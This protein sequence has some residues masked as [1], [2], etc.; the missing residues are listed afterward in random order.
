MILVVG[1]A[2][3]SCVAASA[4]QV[5]FV[6]A[7]R[8]TNRIVNGEAASV[9]QFPWQVSMKQNGYHFCGGSIVGTKYIVSAAHC[10][11]TNTVFVSM[12][13]VDLSDDGAYKREI[14]SFVKHPDYNSNTLDYDYSV[15]TMKSAIPNNVDSV[16]VIEMAAAQ[17][18]KQYSG[19]ATTSGWGYTYGFDHVTPD[20]LY[21]ATLPLVSQSTCQ[22]IWG[23]A[24]TI[25]DRIQCAGGDGVSTVCAGDSGGPLVIKENGKDILIGITSWSESNCSPLYPGGWAKIA[26]ARD[27]IDSQMN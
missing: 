11:T 27:W 17:T 14:V 7:V 3:L 23:H 10:Y 16:Q 18:N 15:L 2:I 21:Y 24:L 20:Q 9:G 22:S 4:P 1:F 19:M 5:D 6:R 8:P 25:T 13:I 26:A 12:G